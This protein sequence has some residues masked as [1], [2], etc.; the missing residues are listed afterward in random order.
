MNLKKLFLYSAIITGLIFSCGGSSDNSTNGDDNGSNAVLSDY[1]PATTGSYWIFEKSELDSN[2]NNKVV[3]S[4]DSF[5]V[6][7]PENIDGKTAIKI[8]EYSLDKNTGKELGVS[9]NYYAL[10]DLNLYAYKS[11]GPGYSKR[12]ILFGNIQNDSWVV[13]ED[14]NIT[15]TASRL[16]EKTI[17][18]AGEEREAIGFQVLINDSNRNLE[19]RSRIWLSPNIGLV[20]KN[21]VYRF[22]NEVIQCDWKLLRYHIN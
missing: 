14:E 17:T 21:E 13:L 12:W 1:F 4:I 19:V 16:D 15:V 18:A 9:S 11:F 7:E 6:A 3:M 22:S 20:N 8:L 2:S 5:V 10:E